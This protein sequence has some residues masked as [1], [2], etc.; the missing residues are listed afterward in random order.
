MI[1]GAAHWARPSARPRRLKPPVSRSTEGFPGPVPESLRGDAQGAVE[2]TGGVL[3]GDDGGQLDQ[4]IVAEVLPEPIEEL[5]THILVGQRHRIGILQG[6]PL[7]LGE[8]R[9]RRVIVE[10]EQ[11]FIRDAEGAADGSVDVLSEEAAIDR[12]D[13]SVDERHQGRVDEP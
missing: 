8:V 4:R 9:A 2:A 10:R 5:V 13:A 7:H 12:G 6:Q 1:R 11:L 3:P